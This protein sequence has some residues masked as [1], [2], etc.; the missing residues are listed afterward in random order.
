MSLHYRLGGGSICN[1]DV[2]FN[3]DMFENSSDNQEHKIT[4]ISNEKN[5]SNE[6]NTMKERRSQRIRSNK[7]VF[8]DK[9]KP[10]VGVGVPGFGGVEMKKDKEKI[11]KLKDNRMHKNDILDLN[12]LNSKSNE[13]E[14]GNEFGS[15]LEPE[16]GL[17]PGSGIEPGLAFGSD[18]SMMGSICFFSNIGSSSLMN[19]PLSTSSKPLLQA[20]STDNTEK[21]SNPKLSEPDLLLSTTEEPSSLP[22][23]PLSTTKESSLSTPLPSLPSLINDNSHNNIDKDIPITTTNIEAVSFMKTS[24]NPAHELMHQLLSSTLPS[25]TTVIDDMHDN[26]RE[27]GDV[28]KNTDDSKHTDECNAIIGNDPSMIKQSTEKISTSDKKISISDGK[29]PNS[30]EI[31]PNCNE[32]ISDN[33][34]KD[35]IRPIEKENLI[36]VIMNKKTKFNNINNDNYSNNNNDN[37]KDNS[38]KDRIISHKNDKNI[39]NHNHDNSNKCTDN[40]KYNDEKGIRIFGFIEK[41]N[42]KRKRENNDSKIGSDHIKTTMN[43]DVFEDVSKHFDTSSSDL[44]VDG[45]DIRVSNRDIQ[46]LDTDIRVSGARVTGD[47]M[48]LLS[49]KRKH[50]EIDNDDK[51]NKLAKDNCNTDDYNDDEC[52]NNNLNDIN[53][54]NKMR[55]KTENDENNDNNSESFTDTE[56][57][58]KID[59][60]EEKNDILK[61]DNNDTNCSFTTSNLLKIIKIK[62]SPE[63]NNDKNIRP[64]IKN[65]SNYFYTLSD[66]N[67]TKVIANIIKNRRHNPNMKRIT[68]TF[69]VPLS[70]KEKYLEL[71]YFTNNMN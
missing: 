60:R 65:I 52:I 45:A 38:N 51:H 13:N 66:D 46:I 68:P 18:F 7:I 21:N 14:R 37:K 34:G 1:N 43:S 19:V 67:Q 40:K 20:T 69:L 31:I 71:L 6:K 32:K 42:E 26:I 27:N 70:M 55:N 57:N 17:E 5:E 3:R 33:L 53:N 44:S 23:L 15:G 47:S 24:D 11:L 12:Y 4:E 56:N 63:P 59:G 2:D 41:I 10:G 9:D 39:N 30:D 36:N 50:S 61:D 62:K 16:S 64:E 29:I 22:S 48:L 54:N 28:S 25:P 49:Q 35:A 8:N 58:E